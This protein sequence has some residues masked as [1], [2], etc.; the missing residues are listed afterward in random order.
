M[1]D[2]LVDFINESSPKNA[3]TGISFI[4]NPTPILPTNHSKTYPDRSAAIGSRPPTDYLKVDPPTGQRNGRG[5]AAEWSQKTDAELPTNHPRKSEIVQLTARP[6]AAAFY[7]NDDSI[8]VKFR[9]RGQPD[10]DVIIARFKKDIYALYNKSIIFYGPTGSGKTTLIHD[11]MYIMRYLFPTV[12]IFA[13]TNAET[14]DYTKLVPMPLIYDSFTLEDIHRL[15]QRQKACANI[16]NI[17]NDKE[18][19]QKLYVRLAD[20]HS[21]QY[22]GRLAAYREKALRQI[23]DIYRDELGTRKTKADELEKTFDTKLVE[24]YKNTIAPRSHKL[25]GLNLNEHEQCA[26]RYINLNPNTLVVFD[27]ATTELLDLIKEGKKKKRGET[28]SKNEETIKNFFFRGRWAYI[29]HWYVFH[30]DAGLEPSI[31][32]NAFYSIF[33]DKP[34]ALA[35][36]QKPANGFGAIE[37]KRAE[38]VINAVFDPAISPSQY[39]KLIYSRME[40]KFYYVIADT[41]DRF[42]MCSKVVRDYCVRI[43]RSESDFHDNNPYLNNFTERLNKH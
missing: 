32:K 5:M 11:F 15:Y 21:K 9:T 4:D 2:F 26:A 42:Q 13:P 25:D 16:Y 41:H 3:R 27:D 20:A 28:T 19:L 24:H 38:A 36:F 7:K 8:R 14:H 17:A 37:K 18:V 31:R 22:I 23:N 40:K 34:T 1:S 35:F 30:D 29:T 6:R 10:E 39:A 12:F 33:T 43:S